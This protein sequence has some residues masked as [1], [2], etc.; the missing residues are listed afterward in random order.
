MNCTKCGSDTTVY[1]TR[2]YN[3]RVVRYR[4][5]TKCSNSFRTTEEAQATWD[6]KVKYEQ[7]YEEV[8]NIVKKRGDEKCTTC[9]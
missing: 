4:R 7:L 5:C 1:K 2:S 8:Q 6:W 3:T 9:G